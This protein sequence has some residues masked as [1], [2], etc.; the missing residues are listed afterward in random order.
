[1]GN[2]ISYVATIHHGP[3][4]RCLEMTLLS[5][6]IVHEVCDIVGYDE[7]KTLL[8]S[9]LPRMPR[10]DT[11]AQAGDVG[12]FLRH[13]RRVAEVEDGGALLGALRAVVIGAEQ[14][15]PHEAGDAVIAVLV[16]E[17]VGHV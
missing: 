17:M 10:G 9:P 5:V 13:F 14:L 6:K 7:R 11:A 8:P 15:V 3:V 12:V 2:S 16:V 1:M 4:C